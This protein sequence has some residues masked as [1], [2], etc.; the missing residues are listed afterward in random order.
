[1]IR[2]DKNVELSKISVEIRHS[3]NRQKISFVGV[4]SKQGA[5]LSCSA[6]VQKL[7]YVSYK[8]K[9]NPYS[10]TQPQ[11][12]VLPTK[13]DAPRQQTNVDRRVA[14]GGLV[15]VVEGVATE[16]ES[17]GGQ[18][19]ANIDTSRIV[20]I[21]AGLSIKMLAYRGAV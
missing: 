13:A 10:T 18:L 7:L 15:V 14:A 17:A 20:Q 11:N 4:S 8:S 19:E 12:G 3:N 16:V 2:R 21:R 6:R 5:R 1:M 9:T